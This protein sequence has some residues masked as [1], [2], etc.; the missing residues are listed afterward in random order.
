MS[1]RFY[2]DESI[3]ALY[4]ADE[5]RE[6][7]ALLTTRNAKEARFSLI[8]HNIRLVIY[9]ASLFSK[10]P[11]EEEDLVS[12]GMIGLIKA[13]DTFDIEKKTRLITYAA[14]CIENEIFSYLRNRIRTSAEISLDETCDIDGDGNERHLGELIADGDDPIG[15]RI[16]CD[17][18]KNSL[19]EAVGRL[20]PRERNFIEMRFGLGDD[21]GSY[22]TQTEIAKLMGVSQ[23][24]LSKFEKK[25]I[26]QLKEEIVSMDG[27]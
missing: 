6:I 9:I 16:E 7:L 13:V 21:S 5:E 22:M 10:D 14:H 12:V 23:A 2:G 11:A 20:T 15:E 18:E 27:S 26:K 1:F 17:D 24:Y 8:E 3:P 25:I 19:K 4:T